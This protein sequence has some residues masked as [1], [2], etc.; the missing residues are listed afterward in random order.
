MRNRRNR[1]VDRR[2]LFEWA[3][4]GIGMA[5]VAYLILLATSL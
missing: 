3:V 4:W 2:A 1:L 5:V